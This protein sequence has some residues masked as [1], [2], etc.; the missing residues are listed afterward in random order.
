MIFRCWCYEP[1]PLYMYILKYTYTNTR[2][3]K[4]DTW[5]ERESKSWGQLVNISQHTET[6]TNYSINNWLSI[7][8][9]TNT[10]LLNGKFVF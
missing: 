4:T 8:V 10:T 1:M 5:R 6:E 7:F 9:V 2:I 3:H